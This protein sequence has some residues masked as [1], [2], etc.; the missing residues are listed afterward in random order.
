MPLKNIILTGS[1]G[2]I[3]TQS[4]GQKMYLSST[5]QQSFPI[6]RITGSSGGTFQN[7]NSSV[8]LHT[9]TELFINVTQSYSES[10]NTIAGI[11]TFIHDTQEEFING[12]FSGSNLMVADQR[13]IDEDCVEFLNVNTTLV[14]YK[15]YFYYSSASLYNATPFSNF[16]NNNTSPNDGE[17]YLYWNEFDGEDIPKGVTYIKIARKD[18]QGNDNTLSLQELTNLRLK[19]SDVSPV[20]DYPIA[21]ITE[22][23]TYYLYTIFPL[24]NVTSSAD[25]N[26]LNHAFSA[27]AV[28]GAPVTVP[29]G[30]LQGYAAVGFTENIDV[31]NYFNPTTGIYTYGDTPNH[32]IHFSASAFITNSVI[33]QDINLILSS[34]SGFQVATT[35][36]FSSPGIIKLHGSA[37]FFESQTLQLGTINLSANSY[38]ISQIQWSFSQSLNPNTDPSTLTVLEPY[39]LS[40]FKNTDCDVTMNNVSEQE[41]SGFYRRVNYNSGATIPTNQQQIISQTAEFADV[42]DY[43]YSARAHILPRYNGVRTV[44]KNENVYTEGEYSIDG[45]TTVDVGFGKTPSVQ[46]LGTY[47]AYFDWMGGTTP[48]LTGKAAAHILYLI[49]VDGNI[50]VPSLSSSYYY[51]LIDN[52]ESDKKAN[53]IMNAISGNPLTI[54]DIP[55]IRA[56]TIPMPII[57]SQT[58]SLSNPINIQSTMSFGT[59]NNN[60]PDYTGT[61]GNLSQQI[62]E[63][64]PGG[65]YEILS[66]PTTFNSSPNV[67]LNTVTS[68]SIISTTS[69]LTKIAFQVTLTNVIAN[70]IYPNPPN[71]YTSFPL[72]L[73][74]GESIDGGVTFGT[75]LTNK[76]TENDRQVSTTPQTLTFTTDFFTPIA[77]RQYRVVLYNMSG[78]YDINIP[79]SQVQIIQQPTRNKE[80]Y[81]GSGGGFFTSSLQSPNVLTGSYSMSLMY[82]PSNPLTQQND[83]D[84]FSSSG[85]YPFL[86]F[87]IQPG[88]Q[89]RFEGD[90]NQVYGIISAK[91]FNAQL[92]SI[93]PL[94][95][96]YN[97]MSILLDGNVTAG[98]NLNSFLIRRFNPNPSFITIDSDLSTYTGGGGF[99]LPKFI[100]NEMQESFDKNVV[101]L[102]ERGLIT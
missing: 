62:I 89:I 74:I 85:Y 56:G 36:T 24:V 88:D 59:S 26:V 76:Y 46:S 35:T 5:E 86:P 8:G 98:T 2:S 65:N 6:E 37:S 48:E 13:L 3:P 39:L 67:T 32:T 42:K 15:T 101:S 72:F 12:E 17:M 28:L 4:Y 19:F 21:T 7:F 77:G 100:T 96:Q 9:G 14:N 63:I 58:G 52:F 27:S 10:I 66:I 68:C 83:T 71:G 23:P 79:S 70:L 64:I 57:A 69:N 18:T 73:F 47:F 49:D 94:V 93:S 54:G 1:I 20:T 45:E 99:I 34:V 95:I 33:E 82:N 25:N 97:S 22:R 78:Y 31:L 84:Q 92:I 41:V 38:D 60:I 61:F 30:V 51:N 75:N 53:I 29:G 16:L 55:I 40:N 44:Q 87:A 80:I 91:P 50:L 81:S 43:N 102:K 11:R 90:E